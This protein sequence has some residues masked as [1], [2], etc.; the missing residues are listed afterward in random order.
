MKCFDPLSKISKQHPNQLKCRRPAKG[1][2]GIFT[3]SYSCP[4][5][6]QNLSTVNPPP[7]I[8]QK[9]TKIYGRRHYNTHFFLWFLIIQH[10]PTQLFTTNEQSLQK[11]TR[12]R[13]PGV[14]AYWQT[15]LVFVEGSTNFC[16]LLISL[17]IKGKRRGH[18][19]PLSALNFQ[20][21]KH[22]SGRRDRWEAVEQRGRK[23]GRA[24]EQAKACRP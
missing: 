21:H 19:F 3:V 13:A 8:V 2:A 4:E 17:E 18:G 20:L 11:T 6:Y 14:W 24:G 9:H 1:E 7:P 5:L 16:L 12:T 23:I 15:P 22:I 10:R